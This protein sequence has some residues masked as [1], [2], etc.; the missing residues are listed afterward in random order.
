MKLAWG[1][2]MAVLALVLAGCDQVDAAT[3]KTSACAEA[4]GLSNIDVHLDPEALAQQA[5]QKADRLRQLASEVSDQ[6]LK[7]QLGTMADSY[8]ALEQRKLDNLSNLNDWLQRNAAN[9]SALREAC[10]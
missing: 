1:S 2:G 7:Q 6:D 10:L 4:L 5:Q 9:L 8:L 3:S